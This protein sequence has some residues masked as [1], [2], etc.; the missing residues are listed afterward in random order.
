LV[1]CVLGNWLW[2]KRSA[3]N[4]KKSWFPL[5]FIEDQKRFSN[6]Q[7]YMVEAKMQ[8]GSS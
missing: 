8:A 7:D 6:V 2:F 5:S 3:R 1:E 4:V